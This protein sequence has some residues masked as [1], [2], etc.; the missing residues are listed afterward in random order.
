MPNIQQAAQNSNDRTPAR[1]TSIH[2][3]DNYERDNL[4][5]ARI[6][7]ADPRRYPGLMTEWA[8]SVL[9]GGVQL[10]LDLEAA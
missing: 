5:A 6:I 8:R 4:R 10:T 9:Y 1:R 7:L 2:R 3:A